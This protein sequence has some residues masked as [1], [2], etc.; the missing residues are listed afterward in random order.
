M[1]GYKGMDDHMRCRGMQY[2]VGK[3]YHV[4]G[5][6][7]LCKNGLHFCKNLSEVFRYYGKYSPHKEINRFFEIETD[8]FISDGYKCVT[9]TLTIIRELTEVEIN[10][11]YYGDGYGDGAFY[12]S[13]EHNGDGYGN[14]DGNAIGDG[15]G[16]GLGYG[17]AYGNGEGDGSKW[18]F[19]YLFHNY[20]YND[21]Q[22][23]LKFI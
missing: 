15:A 19:E 9:S 5:K 23:I 10:R 7:E 4:D 11:C 6:I 16:D 17:D 3:T 12:G 14:S 20:Q 18:G 2:E 13:V 1:R 22:K 21:I 8:T